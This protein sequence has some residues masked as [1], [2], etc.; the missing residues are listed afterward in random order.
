[1]CMCK[2]NV[3]VHVHVHVCMCYGYVYGRDVQVPIPEHPRILSCGRNAAEAQ[4]IE[5]NLRL[6]LRDASVASEFLGMYVTATPR[7]TTA[8]L[9]VAKMTWHIR[10]GA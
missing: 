3:H 5:N 10:S 9:R 1:M 7:M 8:N 2:C 6:A 4:A